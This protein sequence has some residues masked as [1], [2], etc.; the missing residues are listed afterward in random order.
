[1]CSQKRCTPPTLCL[2][3]K[4][5]LIQPLTRFIHEHSSTGTSRDRR[6]RGVEK[7]RKKKTVWAKVLPTESGLLG[8]KSGFSEINSLDLPNWAS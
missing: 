8:N 3:V 6:K 1:M 4:G 2:A 5:P 7:E